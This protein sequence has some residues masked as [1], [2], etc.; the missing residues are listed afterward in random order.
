[1]IPTEE[2]EYWP[3]YIRIAFVIIGMIAWP[4][5]TVINFVKYLK[6]RWDDPS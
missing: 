1:M 5:L 3:W 4:V 6:R 2:P